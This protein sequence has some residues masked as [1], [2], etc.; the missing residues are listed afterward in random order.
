[1]AR[2]INGQEIWKGLVTKH[3]ELMHF[4]LMLT[5]LSRQSK[6][7]DNETKEEIS[8]ACLK[9]FKVMETPPKVESSKKLRLFLTQQ[10]EICISL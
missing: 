4:N 2:K 5:E 1:M 7:I 9:L 3:D 10:G 6:R 8:D